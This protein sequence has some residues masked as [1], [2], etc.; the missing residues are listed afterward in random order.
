MSC[1]TDPHYAFGTI[2]AKSL[3]KRGSILM[4]FVLV[5]PIYIFLFG[6]L[7]LIGDMGL[8]AIRISIGDRD[9]AMDAGDRGG[10]STTQFR[11][12]QM[13]DEQS[14]VTF[15]S[16]TYRADENF[17]GA[18]SWQA[19]GKSYFAYRLQSYGGGLVSYPYLRYG[20]AVSSGGILGTLVGGGAVVFHGK[21]YSLADKVRSY[22]Y[23][24]LK[25]TNLGRLQ[26]DAYRNW[27]SQG[28][29][30]ESWLN[31]ATSGKQYWYRFVFD[32][33]Y[34]DSNADNLDTNPVQGADVTPDP[35]SG[36]KEYK[37][38]EEYVTWSE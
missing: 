20:D 15:G 32:E 29:T 8:N 14:K 36:R 37:R 23:Y 4:E 1:S 27:D 10:N 11:L 24:T 35:P 12:Q 6:A 3:R 13:R 30:S 22:N 38:F 18:W 2:Q 5:L 34:A 31:D 25:R 16:R 19:A 26:Q 28:D 21:D 33:P 17:K 7:F 9:I